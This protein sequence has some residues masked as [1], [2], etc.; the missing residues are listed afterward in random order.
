ML[1]DKFASSAMAGAIE[2][3]R[4]FKLNLAHHIVRQL[5]GDVSARGGNVPALGHGPHNRAVSI[6][7]HPRDPGDVLVYC[8]NGDDALQFKRHLRAAGLMDGR[9]PVDRTSLV[10][11]HDGHR[12]AIVRERRERIQRARAIWKAAGPAEGTPAANYIARARGIELPLSPW[13]GFHS[14]CPRGRGECSLPALVA[15]VSVPTT[16]E[17]RAVHRIYLS[18]DGT[19][20]ADLSREQVKRSLGPT[21]GAAVVLGNL[22]TTD[23]AILEGEGIETVLS[24]CMALGRPGIATLSASTLGRPPLPSGRAVVILADRGAE[25]AAQRAADMRR[26]EGRRV[27]IATP[28]AAFNDWNNYLCA[29]GADAV[30]AVLV[31]AREVL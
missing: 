4:S 25:T 12:T 22:A 13:A 27:W 9:R 3:A 20:K 11:L 15:A 10:A 2:D 17:F 21:S 6:S 26:R 23:R 5:G 30:R 18:A 7:Q 29:E 24:A 28:P 8:H 1:G 19:G 31:N 14:A 16:G